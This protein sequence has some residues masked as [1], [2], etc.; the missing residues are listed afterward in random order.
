MRHLAY[1]HR[2][3]VYAWFQRYA[4]GRMAKPLRRYGFAREPGIPAG[5]ANPSC[6]GQPLPQAPP[7]ERIAAP[8]FVLNWREAQRANEQRTEPSGALSNVPM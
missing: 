8:P 1:S 7:L 4:A 6:A 5:D 2:F 3:Q